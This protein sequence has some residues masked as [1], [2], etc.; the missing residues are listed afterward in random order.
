MSFGFQLGSSAIWTHSKRLVYENKKDFEDGFFLFGSASSSDL[1]HGIGNKKA[2]VG[3][4]YY[5]SFMWVLYPE[6]SPILNAWL[7]FPLYL[8]KNIFK[9]IAFEMFVGKRKIPIKSNVIPCKRGFSYQNRVMQTTRRFKMSWIFINYLKQIQKPGI[10][11]HLWKQ[12]L[13][14]T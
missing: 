2:G 13:T 7:V 1:R 10:Y 3:F 5:A 11:F 4:Q 12:P 6:C 8:P 9:F 14:N